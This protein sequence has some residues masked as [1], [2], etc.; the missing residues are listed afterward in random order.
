MS[1]INCFADL[2]IHIGRTHRGRTVKIT[3]ARNLTFSNILIEAAERKGIDLIGIIDAHSPEVQEEIEDKLSS[4]L[5]REHPDGG[6]VYRQTTCLLGAEVEIKEP[7][8]KPCHILVYLP[9]LA[10]MKQFTVWLSQRQKNVH[11]STQRLYASALDLLEKTLELGG[12]LIPAHIFTP[13]KSV[14][15]SATDRL[16]NLLSLEELVAV[17][18]GLSADTEMADQ[19]DE[20]HRFTFLSNSDAH[21]LGKIG[22]EYQK[23]RLLEPSFQEWKRALQAVEGRKIVANYGLNP[24]LGK[25]HRTRCADC[26]EPLK[27]NLPACPNCGSRR[28]VKGVLERIRELASN[29]TPTPPRPPYHYQVPLDFL[30]GLGPKT[31]QKL[32]D[33]VGTEMQ[34]LHQAPIEDI[35]TVA[36][37][38]I[39]QMIDQARTG[40]LT[41]VEGG[42]GHYGRVK[43]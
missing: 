40:R 38:S 30:P 5:F 3:A 26:Q 15:G 31:L 13:F 17:E 20:L 11:L 23:I 2:H 32:L 36:G 8:M 37:Q 25:Y 10:Q 14:Y 19:L 12:L 35:E 41:L 6:I 18:L 28:I 29:E 4:G 9:T 21:S 24:R 34:I 43:K 16:A 33:R 1:L 42:A 27:P 39:A 22:R 7:G